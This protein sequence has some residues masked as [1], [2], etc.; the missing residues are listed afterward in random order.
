M[1]NKIIAH[2]SI[3]IFEKKLRT[4]DSFIKKK[5]PK[6]KPAS[7]KERSFRLVAS[8]RTSL[9]KLYTI[10]EARIRAILHLFIIP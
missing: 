7:K 2:K 1:D 6:P 8:N 4:Q 5:T 10:D 3:F 9:F